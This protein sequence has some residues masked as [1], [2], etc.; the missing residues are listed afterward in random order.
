MFIFKQGDILMKIKRILFGIIALLTIQGS[1]SATSSTVSSIT[2]G[3]AESA[4]AGIQISLVKLLQPYAKATPG[5]LTP[6]QLVTT[7]LIEV[8]PT[9]LTNNPTTAGQNYYTTVFLGVSPALTHSQLTA[10]Q[11]AANNTA[12]TSANSAQL[13]A[14]K[15]A[16]TTA[17]AQ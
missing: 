17:L 4:A 7:L 9:N 12:V 13:T 11:T 10:L 3:A 1:I 2:V 15:A 5:S 16:L 6:A 8:T 14:L